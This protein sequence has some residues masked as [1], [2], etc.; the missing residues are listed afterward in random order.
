MVVTIWPMLRVRKAWFMAESA[1]RGAVLRA[2]TRRG[3]GLFSAGDGARRGRALG[4]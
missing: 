4:R 3:A 1:R 2:L